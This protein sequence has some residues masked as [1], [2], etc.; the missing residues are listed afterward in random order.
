VQS[1]I[2]KRLAWGAMLASTG[3]LATIVAHRASEALYRQIFGEDPP[4]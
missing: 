2:V 3:A 4:E 1:E